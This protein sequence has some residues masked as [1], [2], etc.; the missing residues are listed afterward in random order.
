MMMT[1]VSPATPRPLFPICHTHPTATM[2]RPYPRAP[3]LTLS[4]HS[5]S[6]L[7]VASV[8]NAIQPHGGGSSFF[9]SHG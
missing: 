7:S 4:S 6:V 3:S 5:S 8:L 2:N 9:F 1:T